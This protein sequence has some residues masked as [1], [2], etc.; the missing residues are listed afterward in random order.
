M[1]EKILVPYDMSMLSDKALEHAV[2][3][4][5]AINNDKAEVIL[6]HVVAELPMYPLIGIRESSSEAPRVAQL[7]K[8]IEK[9]HE[10]AIKYIVQMIEKKG[11]EKDALLGIAFKVEVLKGTPVEKILEYAKKEKV[12]LIVLGSEGW[13][14]ISKSK[15]LG[16]IAR[17]VV[18]RAHCPVTVVH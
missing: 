14:E 8:H 1:Y 9:V 17:G 18:E 6:L 3:L 4:S 5:K 12:D 11:G 2:K 7:V 13:G 15:T 10:E 16:S